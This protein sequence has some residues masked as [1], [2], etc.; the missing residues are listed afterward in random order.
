MNP[1]NTVVIYGKIDI[2]STRGTIERAFQLALS[3]SVGTVSDLKAMLRKEG[4][5]A[6]DAT[7]SGSA[8]KTE[9]RRLC[10][11]NCVTIT[12]MQART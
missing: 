12:P 8:L 4:H 5:A 2:G 1:S 10:R 11:I 9:L 6:V 3:G 7:F